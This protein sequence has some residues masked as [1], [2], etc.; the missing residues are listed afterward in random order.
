MPELPEVETIRGQLDK[1][2][3]GKTITEVE[4]LR[5]KSFLGDPRILEG[6]KIREVKR[7][8]KVIEIYFEGAREMVIVHL[9]MTG[10]M[11]YVGGHPTVDWIRELPSKHTRVVWTFKDRA[12][13]FFNDMRVFGW[14][15]IVDL[16]EYE[17]G[18]RRTIPDVIDEGFSTE[19]LFTVL[20]RSRKPVKLVLLDQDKI[21]GIGN[22]YVND[23]LFLARINPLRASNSLDDV[24]TKRLHSAVVKVIKLGIKYGGASAA[25]EKFVNV[26]GLGGTYQKHFLVYQKNGQKCSE[27]GTAI[28]KIKLGGRGTFYC[29]NCQV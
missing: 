26:F 9:K 25:D 2:L 27:C 23:A 5:A 7:K 13:L 19:Y 1:V 21:G 15:K 8:A 4:V 14:M 18:K 3:D 28:E 24:E 11:V 29:P 16:D 10:Q 20:K 22:I 6:K 17:K 12:K